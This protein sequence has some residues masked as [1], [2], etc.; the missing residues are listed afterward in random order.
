MMRI[1]FL[2]RHPRALIWIAILVPFVAFAFF[3]YDREAPVQIDDQMSIP[4]VRAGD[5]LNIELTVKRDLRRFC[6]MTLSRDLMT[7]TSE[8][9]NLIN[10]QRVSPEGI[11]D[12]N[13]LSPGKLDIL[14]VIPNNTPSGESHILTNAA[15]TCSRNPTTW[16]WPIEANYDWRFMVLPP[17]PK[18]V[19]VLPVGALPLE[20][21]KPTGTP[22]DPVSVVIAKQPASAASATK[23]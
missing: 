5:E 7:S 2:Y 4:A 1:E 21:A 12:R 8:R 10:N 23:P 22:S 19:I 9:K 20:P 14:I 15:F 3:F 13:R 16:V 6:S 11:R 17:E 18:A